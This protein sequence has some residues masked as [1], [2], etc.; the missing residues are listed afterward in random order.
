MKAITKAELDAMCVATALFHVGGNVYKP[1]LTERQYRSLGVNGT[2]HHGIGYVLDEGEAYQL[3]T[4]APA[5]PKPPKATK[6]G[7]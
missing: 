5:T 7:E 6:E 4:P 1:V 2:Y 3:E